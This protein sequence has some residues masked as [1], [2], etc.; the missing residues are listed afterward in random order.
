MSNPFD[1]LEAETAESPNVEDDEETVETAFVDEE[2]VESE[3][4]KDAGSVESTP[5]ESGPAFEYDAVRQRPLYAR[6][7]TWDAFEKKLRTTITPTLAREDVVDEETRE[8]HDAV[9]RLAT[10]EPERIAELVLEA[11]RKE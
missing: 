9:L 6:G 8:I 4:A 2:S 5:A 11:R 3:D 10:E 7:E 1:D